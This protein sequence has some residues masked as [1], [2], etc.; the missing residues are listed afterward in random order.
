MPGWRL[1]HRPV[2]EDGGGAKR[3]RGGGEHLGQEWAV[4]A[5]GEAGMHDADMARENCEES[6]EDGSPRLVTERCGTSNNGMS[7][8][9]G[10]DGKGETE[11]RSEAART[12]MAAD[13]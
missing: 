5:P 8:R 6:E 9:E 3:A 11:E 7:G 13:L 4:R 12:E 10:R 1:V 2:V